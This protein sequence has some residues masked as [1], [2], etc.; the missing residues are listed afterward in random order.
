MRELFTTII[1]LISISGYAQRTKYAAQINNDTVTR[2]IVIESSEL[3]ISLFGGEWVETF[4]DSA[5]KNYAGIGY[6]YIRSKQNFA[7]PK[8]FPSWSLDDNCIWQPPVPMPTDEKYYIWDE[9]NQKW[10][11]LTN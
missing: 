6:L 7:T 5:G 1:L 2:I 9:E 3:A 4:I 11:E 10:V 8:P